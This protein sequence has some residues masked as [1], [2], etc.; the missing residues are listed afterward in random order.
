MEVVGDRSAG[1]CRGMVSAISHTLTKEYNAEIAMD[2]GSNWLLDV[3][4]MP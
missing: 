3:G 1:G 4:T 2:S